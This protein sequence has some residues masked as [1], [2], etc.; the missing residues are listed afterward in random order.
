MGVTGP[1]VKKNIHSFLENIAIDGYC[2]ETS[3]TTVSIMWW[4]V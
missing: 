1:E 4:Q 2:A 3:E